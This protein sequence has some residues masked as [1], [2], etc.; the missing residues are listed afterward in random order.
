MM[1]F[2]FASTGTDWGCARVPVPL[3]ILVP[4]LY[5]QIL[6]GSG[7]YFTGMG[8]YGFE[9]TVVGTLGISASLG[10]FGGRSLVF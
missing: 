2:F 4:C 9:V 8:W 6:A 10:V 5:P 7:I 3:G 1:S